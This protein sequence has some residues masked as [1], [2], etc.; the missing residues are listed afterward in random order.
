MRHTRSLFRPTWAALAASALIAACGGGSASAPP[1]SEDTTPPTVAIT[2]NVSGVDAATGNILF[3]FTFSEAVTDFSTEDVIVTGGDKGTFT[4]VSDTVATLLVTPTANST[5]TVQV[6]VAAGAFSDFAE[7]ASVTA[8]NASQAFDTRPVTTPSTTI[9]TF[10]ESPAAT[11]I[12]FEGASFEAATDGTR[13]VAK[14]NKLTTSQPWAGATLLTCPAGTDGFTPA[15]PFTAN[16]QSI[17]VMVKAPRAGVVFT[18]K[19]EGAGANAGSAVFAQTSNTGTDW[20]KLTFNFANKTAG[21]DLDITKVYNKFSI[22][23]NWTEVATDTANRVAETS[24]RVYLF[25][26]FKFEGV[27]TTLNPCPPSQAPASASADPTATPVVTVFSDANGYTPPNG[28]TWTFRTGWSSADYEPASVANNNV[29]KYSNLSFVG[30]QPD[31][32]ATVDASSASHLNLDVWTPNI[33][34]FRIKLVDFGANGV[35]E[36]TNSDNTE[37]EVSVDMSGHLGQWRRIRIP[38]SDF[39]GLTARGHLAQIIFSTPAA[40]TVFVDNVFFSSN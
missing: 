7:N 2:D 36:Q 31:N 1:G 8:S 30:I 26:D 24:D 17:S 9:A 37:H 38:L 39:T 20:E 19:A 29:L 27:S 25:D 21:D 3:T 22:F 12:A 34:T 11:L 23:P 10:E 28:I 13:Q 32:D 35:W 6:S 15:I 14:L 16:H 4:I 5:G 33:S 40:G 18:L